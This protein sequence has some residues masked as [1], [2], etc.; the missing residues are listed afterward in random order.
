RPRG[1][2][3]PDVFPRRQAE[4]RAVTSVDVLA[5][6]VEDRESFRAPR[7]EIVAAERGHLIKRAL[8]H[9]CRSEPRLAAIR[10]QVLEK[11]LAFSLR[12]SILNPMRRTKI[13]CTLGPATEKP[14]TI[15]AL[16][17]A[18]ADI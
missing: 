5:A 7:L 8:V 11:R 14:E 18:G 15:R 12:D 6:Q 3:E 2:I 17:A 1:E 9:V 10:N 13:I 4:E 16:L